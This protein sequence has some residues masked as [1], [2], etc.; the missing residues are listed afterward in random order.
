[1]YYRISYSLFGQDDK[2]YIGAIKNVILNQNLLPTWETIIYYHKDLTKLSYIETLKNMGAITVDVSNIK[3]GEKSSNQFPFF[4]R[5]LSF[6]ENNIS[7]VRDLDSRLSPRE[8]QY[9]E[10]WLNSDCDYFI[11]RDHPWHSP[12]PSG[13][14]GIKGYKENF[15]THFINFINKS[16]LFWGADQEILQEY[17]ERINKKDVSYFGYDDP[18]SYI[19]RDD[20]N[21]F[22]GIQLDENDNPT[23][24]SGELCLNYLN[25]LNL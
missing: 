25:E 7:I 3:I 6:L 14:F 12:V 8:V 4:W 22:I 10:R 21:F 24:P 20:K 18:Q 15:H 2:Y 11:I 19:P 9:I 1:M 13:L 23:V 17:M 5:F 16:N